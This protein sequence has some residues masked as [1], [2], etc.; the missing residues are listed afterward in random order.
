[1]PQ[2]RLLIIHDALVGMQALADVYRGPVVLEMD[3]KS[4]VKDLN[5]DGHCLS[6]WC[7]TIQDIKQALSLF[8][9][10]KISFALRECNI[11]AHELAAEAKLK[12]NLKMIAGVPDR[13]QAC[14][15]TDCSSIS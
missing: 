12:G 5:T 7:G 1:M 4:V 3:C 8:T 15:F 6:P 14:L 13:L 9:E 11:M 2:Q 10:H